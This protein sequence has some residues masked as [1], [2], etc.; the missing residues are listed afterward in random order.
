[1]P[2]LERP[3]VTWTE[4]C[5]YGLIRA[6]QQRGQWRWRIPIYVGIFSILF[7]LEL[8][9]VVA[10]KPVRDVF[11]PTDLLMWWAFAT[12][13]LWCLL[14]VASFL[15]NC[16]WI[17]VFSTRIN[18]GGC[19]IPFE[20]VKSVVWEAESDYWVVRIGWDRDHSREFAVSSEKRPVLL[21][22]LSAVGARS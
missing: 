9:L 8:A 22:A 4:P 11:S 5:G 12:V 21:A 13:S 2:R 19:N 6:R 10:G 15:P 18:I 17:W 7:L 1:M 3:L 14:V 20:L 16:R